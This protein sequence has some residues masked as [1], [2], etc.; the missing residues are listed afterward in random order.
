MSTP[1]KSAF[2]HSPT[3]TLENIK[4]IANSTGKEKILLM[5]IF[6]GR[7]PKMNRKQKPLNSISMN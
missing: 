1:K 4:A 5:Q 7:R 3:N 6:T 2:K